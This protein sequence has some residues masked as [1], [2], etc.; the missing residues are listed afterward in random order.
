MKKIYSAVFLIA[1]T[2]GSLPAASQLISNGGSIVIEDGAVITVKGNLATNAP[3]GGTSKVVMQGTK[4]QTI[5]TNGSSLYNLAI[6][7]PENVILGSSLQVLNQ[8]SFSSGKLITD[9]NTVVVGGTIVGYG[10]GNYLVT[11][12]GGKLAMNNAGSTPLIFP[13]GSSLYSY[14]P[15]TLVNSGAAD[16]FRVGVKP[17]ALAFGTTGDSVL[18]NAVDATWDVEE[19]VPGGSNVTLTVQWI[20]VEERERFDRSKAYLSQYTGTMWEVSPTVGAAGNDPYTISRSGLTAFSHF[21]VLSPSTPLPL[22]MITFSAQLTDRTVNLQWRTTGEVNTSHFEVERSGTGGQYSRLGTVAADKASLP[23]HDYRFADKAPLNGVNV[24]RLKMVDAN[25]AFTY[26]NAVV[27]KLDAAS[28]VQL[29]PNPASGMLYL[30]VNGMSENARL[31]IFDVTG[32]Q[33]RQ[34]SF[35]GTGTVSISLDISDLPKGAYHLSL[36]SAAA[37]HMQTFTKQ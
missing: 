13:V 37:K 12:Q 14:Q 9:T 2:A 21:T 30:Q 19:E 11:Q 28:M 32:R 20:G 29:F 36:S 4:L 31:Q 33:V 16:N 3:I 6:D 22:K 18:A 25:G 24:Y 1:T 10:P 8:L 27:V 34:Q 15:L 7:N 26:S 35:N 5:N 17:N 23:T